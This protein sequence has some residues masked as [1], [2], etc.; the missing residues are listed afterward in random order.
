[1]PE[2]KRVTMK[3]DVVLEIEPHVKGDDEKNIMNQ[4]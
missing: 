3:L 4:V 2:E 1:L